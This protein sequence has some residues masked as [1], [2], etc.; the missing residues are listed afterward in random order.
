[1]NSKADSA[2]AAHCKGV[3]GKKTHLVTGELA[4]PDGLAYTGN[5]KAQTG[6]IPP[7]SGP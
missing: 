1:M 7:A 3:D 5:P 2:E 4:D 6:P